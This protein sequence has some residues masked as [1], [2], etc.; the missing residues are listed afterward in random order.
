MQ[1]V[2]K[3]LRPALNDLSP[4]NAG[5]SISDIRKMYDVE[6]IA[7]LG[8]NENPFG[9]APEVLA[10]LA[11]GMNE[12]YLYPESNAGKLRSVLAEYLDLDE[13]SLVFGNGSEELL[14]IISRSVVEPG[15]RVVTLYPSFP[16]H[17]DYVRLM[18]GIIEPVTVTNELAIDIDKLV[19]AVKQPA[20]MLIF[21]NPM[22]PVGAWLSPTELK[23][24]LAATHP[25]TLI[26]LDE[27]YHEYASEG[28]Y[29]SGLEYLTPENGNWIVL[30]TFSKAWGLAGMRI[31]FGVCSSLALR[32]ALDLTRTPFNIN[33]LAQTAAISAI[34]QHTYMKHH[35]ALTNAAKQKVELELAAMGL[36]HAKSLG[37]FLFFD[38]GRSSVEVAG[39]FLKMGT[40][41]K[42]WKQRGFDTFIR[43]SIGKDEENEQFLQN[44]RMIM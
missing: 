3:I 11:S 35:V 43:V 39:Q 15:D 10:Q 5:L 8:S 24:V 30:R 31:G 26:V 4:Y 6:R 28:D 7:K 21:A 37:N 2:E 9:P 27:A 32:S 25:D 17:E 38:T 12:L 20:K 33:S 36:K 14:S 44:L 18:G 1:T 19:D 29:A 34:E 16:L 41:V 40:I 23:A 22:N 13:N 42:P